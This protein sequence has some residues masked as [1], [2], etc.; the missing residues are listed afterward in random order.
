MRKFIAWLMFG[1]FLF[2]FIAIGLVVVFIFSVGK[3]TDK[4][5]I[6]ECLN[7]KAQA[8]EFPAFFLTQWQADQCKAHS[9]FINAEVIK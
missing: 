9:I 6:V 5:E 8:Q 3:F 2:V 4:N 7:W 1:D